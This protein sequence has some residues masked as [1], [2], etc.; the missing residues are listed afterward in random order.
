[1]STFFKKLVGGFLVSGS[2]MDVK[3]MLDRGYEFH[4]IGELVKAEK[5]YKKV[6]KEDGANKDG[7]FLL[8][9]L[10]AQQRKYGEAYQHL[11]RTLELNPEFIDARIEL[12]KMQTFEGRRKDAQENYLK[13]IE[14]YTHEKCAHYNDATGK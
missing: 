11:H 3:A 10:Y 6:L 8:G 12:A 4:T 5:L 13:V 14:V 1:M 7:L 2:E 9:R